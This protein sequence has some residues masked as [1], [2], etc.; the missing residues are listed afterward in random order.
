MGVS[1]ITKARASAGP[2]F[3]IVMNSRTFHGMMPA[4]TPT[5]SWRTSA[6]PRK[7]GRTSSKAKLRVRLTKLV[8][9]ENSP[10]NTG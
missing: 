4:H 5:G 7:P 2:I 10:P 8:L 1:S 6:G 3:S 9:Y